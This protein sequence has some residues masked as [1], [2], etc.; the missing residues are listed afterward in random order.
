M[1]FA[2]KSGRPTSAVRSKRTRGLACGGLCVLKEVLVV[3]SGCAPLP[4]KKSEKLYPIVVL[5]H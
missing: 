1:A 4:Q 2:A 3:T 5:N